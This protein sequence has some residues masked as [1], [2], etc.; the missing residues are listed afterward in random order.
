MDGVCCDCG[1]MWIS[2]LSETPPSLLPPCCQLL[3]WIALLP[4]SIS[5]LPPLSLSLS[6]CIFYCWS[7]LQCSCPLL[8]PFFFI[9]FRSLSLRITHPLSFLL[10]FHPFSLNKKNVKN[11]YILIVFNYLNIC[12]FNKTLQLQHSKYFIFQN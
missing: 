2:T 7:R 9:Y 6:H 5:P 4:S 3:A 8:C 1:C 10:N 11:K 12:F